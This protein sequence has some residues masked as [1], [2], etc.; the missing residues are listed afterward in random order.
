V[1]AEITEKTR[2][3]LAAGAREV[4]LVAQNGA[5]RF[6]DRTGEIPRSC[7]PVVLSL[8]DVTNDYL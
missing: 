7:F 6:I 1:E 5:V 4:W 2:A 8:P 3:Y